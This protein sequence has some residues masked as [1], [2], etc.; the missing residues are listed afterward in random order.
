VLNAAAAVL[1]G[2][3]RGPRL[4]G[5]GGGGVGHLGSFLVHAAIWH[6]VGQAVALVFRRFPAIAT[7][8][9]ST[10]PAT[11]QSPCQLV[12]IEGS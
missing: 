3:I 7:L 4:G 6:I 5:H 1:Y 2:G 11:L 12:P 10:P 8:G 9:R